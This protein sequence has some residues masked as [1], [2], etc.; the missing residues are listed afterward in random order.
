[1]AQTCPLPERLDTAAAP[2]LKA[3]LAQHMAEAEGGS[4]ALDVTHVTYVGGLCLQLLLASQCVFVG[5]SEAVR[6]AYRLFG[7]EAYLTAPC[8]VLEK[9]T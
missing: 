2:Q 9:E 8:A 5:L 4:V 3:L 1:M 6:E 7:V